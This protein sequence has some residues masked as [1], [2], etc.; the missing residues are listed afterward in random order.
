MDGDIKMTIK[1]YSLPKGIDKLPVGVEIHGNSVRINFMFQNR[2]CKE[3]LKNI[4]RI[5]KPNIVYAGN[6]V[7]MVKKDIRDDKFDYAKYFP[8]SPRAFE[9]IAGR[10]I[11][12]KRNIGDGVDLY[13]R[14]YKLNHQESGYKK[15]ISKGNHVKIYFAE[16]REIRTI[17]KTEVEEFKAAL[18]DQEGKFKL[19]PKTANLVLGVLRKV[20]DDALD[21]MIITINVARRVKS[22][23]LKKLKGANADPLLRKEIET[24]EGL[25][26]FRPQDQNMFLFN[27][28]CG[29]SVSELRGLA[30]KDVDLENGFIYIR[31]IE[32]EGVI[33][34]PK[35]MVRERKI[36][37]LEPAKF[38]LKK[39]IKFTSHNEP[40]EVLVTQDDSTTKIK[41]FVSFVFLNDQTAQNNKRAVPFS[42]P[43]M[44]RWF[45]RF[46]EA[47]N[48]RPRAPNQCRHTFASQ[49]LSAFAPLEWVARMLGH[50][51]IQM[52][53]EHYGTWIPEDTKPMAKLVSEM[54]GVDKKYNEGLDEKPAQTFKPLEAI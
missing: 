32:V 33:K 46:L 38:W 37:L 42:Q 40:V 23:K 15:L 6:L 36:E 14:I 50:S 35:E 31:R 16:K 49:A 18:V 45:K 9:F 13:L 11:D 30:W 2:R 3:P 34:C 25:S 43:T 5:T 44:E 52:L 54:M 48:I 20:M 24:L 17:K 12:T 1:Q 19:A 26:Y 4:K 41:E 7:S 53:K 51:D 22:F 28:W 21:D 39:Q 29:L 27:M 47:G 8:E 10:K